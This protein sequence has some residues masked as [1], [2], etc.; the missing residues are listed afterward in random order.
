MD[1]ISKVRLWPSALLKCL[2]WKLDLK[3]QNLPIFPRNWP[4]KIKN[5]CMQLFLTRLHFY[6]H[7]PNMRV[8]VIPPSCVTATQHFASASPHSKNDCSLANLQGHWLEMG[9]TMALYK[10][11]HEL[12]GFLTIEKCLSISLKSE[13]H[14]LPTPEHPQR[15]R[16]VAVGE[17]KESLR[18]NSSSSVPGL[19]SERGPGT[20]H[21]LFWPLGS[22]QWPPPLRLWMLGP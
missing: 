15:K 5:H 14:P 1:K 11:S 4:G 10:S 22:P 2:T 21:I 12:W 3:C 17:W 7:L 13:S 19:Q 6:S 20:A 16:P 8:N 9:D 18:K